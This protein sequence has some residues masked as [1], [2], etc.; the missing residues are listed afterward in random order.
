MAQQTVN[1]GSS[2]NDGTGDNL[3]NAFI[4]LNTNFTEIYGLVDRNQKDVTQ[5]SH[6]FAVKDVLR[7]T[8]AGAYAKISDPDTQEP[9]GIVSVVTD[10]NN[11]T[12][13]EGG[14][15][16]TLSGLTANTVYY[17]QSSGALGTGTTAL[18][19]F[20]ATSATSGHILK[21]SRNG[22]LTLA[23]VLANGADANAIAI[24]NLA[25][26]TDDQD[27]ATKVWVL[28]QISTP[29]LA[30]VL[31][32]GADADAIAI[33]NM[34]DPTDPQ[35]AATKAYV[36][37]AVSSSLDLANVLTNDNDGGGLLIKNI[38]NPV[39]DQDA[40]TK[41]WTLAQISTPDL[42][43]VL[44][45]DADANGLNISN[46]ADPINNQ[47]AATRGW[48]INNF[49][50]PNLT[51]VLAIGNSAGSV[52]ITNVTDPVDGQDAATKA[53]VLTQVG[54]GSSVGSNH[55]I[56]KG[57]GAGNFVGTDIYSSTNGSLILGDVSL[58]GSR[59]LSVVSSTGNAD[60]ILD[61]QGTTGGVIVGSRYLQMGETTD[62]DAVRTLACAGTET[63][64]VFDIYSKGADAWLDLNGHFQVYEINSLRRASIQAN[65]YTGLEF[66]E[67]DSFFSIQSTA[68]TSGSADLR[69]LSSGQGAVPSGHIFLAT[70]S[71]GSETAQGNIGLHTTSV[72]NWQSME[73][74]L[75]IGDA[76][77]APTG[78]PSGGSFVW[79]ESN[80][81][82]HRSPDGRVADM[83]H[84]YSLMV[85]AL[86]SSPADA[87]TIYFGQLPKAPTTTAAT[88]KVYI[89]R[90]GTIKM[91]NIYCYSGTAGT[92]EA[93]TIYI[94]KNNTTDTA[95]ATVSAA[96]N[97]RVFANSSL[98]IA[99][100]AGDYIEI[101]SIN[102]TWATNPLT[103][104]FGGFLYIE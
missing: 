11:F 32:E 74:G 77:A 69:L 65:A 63:N 83:T 90:A 55:E 58:A 17:V 60:L 48:V 43:T 1:I 7:I 87:T 38:G 96:T 14:F 16:S 81:L 35:D 57:D 88:S 12:M 29:S 26:P 100:A 13:V 39:D 31:G 80:N 68:V 70:A 51:E 99:V 79:E 41:V 98:S 2:A 102:P 104:V 103:C 9:I 52:R 64:I 4:K 6:G 89:R 50:V 85:Q 78:N 22:N 75:F 19:Y 86:T 101:K 93:W 66:L 76:T 61:P 97:E 15:V 95:I 44:A 47:D 45:V 94:R 82:Y 71:G 27:A 20:H 10:S 25:D 92:N 72:S 42:A 34:A 5:A 18:K 54:S 62:G 49:G 30:T 59:T 67:G 21:S 24:T 46:L 8:T 56:Q 91:A 36:D 23:Q 40:A 53:W 37:S 28:A 73:N 33:T 3:R 84:G